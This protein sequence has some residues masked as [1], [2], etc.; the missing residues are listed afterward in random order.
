V[1]IEAGERACV[2]PPQGRRP[3][4]PIRA[5]QCS[6]HVESAEVVQP[7]GLAGFES[8]V[9]ILMRPD[10]TSQRIRFVKTERWIDQLG[11]QRKQRF[12]VVW[13]SVFVWRVQRQHLPHR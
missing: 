6:S 11:I 1:R 5:V 8:F 2:A 3:A 7:V 13:R 12:A 4:G 10:V 9:R